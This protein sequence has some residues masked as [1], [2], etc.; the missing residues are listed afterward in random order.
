M[1]QVKL[2]AEPRSEFGSR[3]AR[4]LRRTGR[5]PA[6][7]YGRDLAPMTVSVDKRE[8]Y[9]VLHTESGANALIDLA[10]EGEKKGFLTVAREVQRDPVRG[11]VI[12]LDFISI[13]LDHAIA[14]EVHIEYLGVPDDTKEGGVVETIRTSVNLMALPMDIPASIPLDISKMIIGDTLKVSDLPAIDGVEYSD[15]PETG[16]VTV[17]VPRLVVDDVA[18]G[19]EGVE[20]EEGEG[21]EPAGDAGEGES[22]EGDESS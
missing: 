11:E 8:L 10:V 3:T 15:D 9:G 18:E 21:E 4:R 6:L 12:H 17:L 2:R 14:A 20:G 5:V 13:S 1:D 16:L 7:V 22:A 19:A